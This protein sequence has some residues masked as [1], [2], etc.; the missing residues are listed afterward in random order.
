MPHLLLLA[1]MLAAAVALV[2]FAA[3]A[4]LRNALE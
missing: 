3:A 2:P 4:A 1:S